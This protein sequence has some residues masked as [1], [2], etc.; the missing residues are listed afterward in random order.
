[1]PLAPLS[2]RSSDRERRGLDRDPSSR[3]PAFPPSGGLADTGRP[4]CTSSGGLVNFDTGGR[5]KGRDSIPRSWRAA[6]SHINRDSRSERDTCLSIVESRSTPCVPLSWLSD[7]NKKKEREKEKG[8]RYMERWEY[9][10]APFLYVCRCGRWL[11]KTT[12]LFDSGV[13]PA[14]RSDSLKSRNAAYVQ[15]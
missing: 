5:H 4:N 7:T 8:E 15:L 9:N 11:T 10:E 3:L 6:A 13:S 14:L 2:T 1:M 12:A